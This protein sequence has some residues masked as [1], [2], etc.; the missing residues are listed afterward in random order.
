VEVS[1]LGSLAS[2]FLE[3]GS[4]RVPRIMRGIGLALLRP[5]LRPQVCYPILRGLASVPSNGDP[6]A[7]V[8]LQLSDRSVNCGVSC[9]DLDVGRSLSAGFWKPASSL[10]VVQKDFLIFFDQLLKF[11]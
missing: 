5:E 9:C 11:F 2:R 6:G 4:F 1:S 3:A 7:F 8:G 10:H